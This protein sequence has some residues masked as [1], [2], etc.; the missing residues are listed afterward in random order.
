MALN[1]NTSAT[2]QG[3]VVVNALLDIEELSLRKTIDLGVQTKLYAR[4]YD[5]TSMEDHYMGILPGEVLFMN[6][7]Q[8]HGKR[9]RPIRDT[10]LIV[11]SSLNGILSSGSTSSSLTK[12]DQLHF[13]G[14]ADILSE[15]DSTRMSD[16]G[17]LAQVGGIRTVRNTGTKKIKPGDWVAWSLPDRSNVKTNKKNCRR[18]EPGELEPWIL[19]SKASFVPTVLQCVSFS[20]TQ[21]QQQ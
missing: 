8:L 17:A 21:Q 7:S 14:F 18:V 4:L 20:R 6:A 10:H 2:Q 13:V 12:A 9:Y 3:R 16:T 11:F 15:F 19:G 5:N 1:S